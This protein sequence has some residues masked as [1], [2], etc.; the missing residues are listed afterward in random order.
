[1]L[2]FHMVCIHGSCVDKLQRVAT[3]DV[4]TVFVIM[5]PTMLGSFVSY[6]LYAISCIEW[7]HTRGRSS[8][9][10][11]S[12]SS[13]NN[14]MMSLSNIAVTMSWCHEVRIISYTNTRHQIIAVTVETCSS[15]TNYL[16]LSLITIVVKDEVISY[17]L[18]S[19]FINSSLNIA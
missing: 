4:H 12:L 9:E 14:E 5:F 13:S 10:M 11:M 2:W 19:T 6:K 18:L 15:S 3:T 1:M 7:I 16:Y 8:N 17:D